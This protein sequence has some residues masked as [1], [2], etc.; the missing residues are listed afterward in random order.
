MIYA[1]LASLLILIVLPFVFSKGERSPT[2]RPWAPTVVVL[3]ATIVIGLTAAGL[4][5]PW[6][7]AFSAEL[8]PN[9]VD[10]RDEVVLQGARLLE[11][12]GC[13]NC[14][15][16]AGHGGH[17]APEFT[18]IAVRLPPQEITLRIVNGFRGMP[19]YRDSLTLE[20]LNAIVNLLQSLDSE[21]TSR[22]RSVND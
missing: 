16:L 6:V 12:E 7:P 13:L 19:A 9:V 22:G 4:N 10:T 1:P 15:A 20:E 11:T 21:R 5:A 3:A 18:D 2:R 17:L 8:P 14:H